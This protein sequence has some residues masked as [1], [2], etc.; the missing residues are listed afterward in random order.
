MQLLF[1]L[2]RQP[3]PERAQVA[4]H[5][6][7]RYLIGVAYLQQELIG[8]ANWRIR[9]ASHESRRAL[10]TTGSSSSQPRIEQK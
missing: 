4:H 9:K 6:C 3:L 8:S 2:D 7:R 5:A 10:Y 1:G